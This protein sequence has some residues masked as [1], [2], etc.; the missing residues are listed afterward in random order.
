M[1]LS[2]GKPVT[3]S[4][5]KDEFK[6]D[7]LT[8]ELTK[9]FWLAEANDERQWVMIDL[10]KPADVYAVQINYHDY[11]SN[12]YGRYE[13][14]H[15]RYL[16]E[17]SLDGENW[18]ILV[19]CKESYRDTPNDYV[20]LAL[21][22]SAR[23]IRYKNIDIPTPN[24]AISELRVFGLG[25]GKAPQQ[26]KKLVLDRQADRERCARLQH[27]LGHCT[28]QTYSSWMVYDKTDL[29]M[30]ALTADQDYYFCVEAFNENGVS[31]RSEV[32]HVK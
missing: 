26:P 9:T 4:T 23:Y 30:K 31:L 32:K 7:A 6:A 1:L 2:Y 10:E 12:M 16:I 25:M 21:P 22:K 5:T 20:E 8:D 18:E 11:Q 14:L 29:L 19:D 24:L 27:T 15:H 3:A 17:G 28:G 13:G